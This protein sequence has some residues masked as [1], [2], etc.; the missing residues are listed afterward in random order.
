M[1][2]PPCILSTE[3]NLR[4][5]ALVDYGTKYLMEISLKNHALSVETSL[6]KYALIAKTSCWN[7]ASFACGTIRYLLK[8]DQ[9]MVYCLLKHASFAESS[10]KL[11]TDV[12][13]KCRFC[14]HFSHHIVP[15][16]AFRGNHNSCN[17]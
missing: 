16:A 5:Y 2:Y 12:A 10:L 14:L 15:L 17:V 8:L 1:H 11:M 4:K 9:E 7:H 6:R 3:I 13:N